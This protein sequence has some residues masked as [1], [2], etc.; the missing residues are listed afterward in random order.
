MKMNLVRTLSEVREVKDRLKN[1]EIK[2]NKIQKDLKYS[3]DFLDKMDLKTQKKL[4][5][6]KNTYVFL[7]YLN[8]VVPD[9]A[10]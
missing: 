1:I 10:C 7:Q 6:L 4:D 3:V 5:E 9:K 8:K 2:V